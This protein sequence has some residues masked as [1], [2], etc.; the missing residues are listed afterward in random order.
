MSALFTI[1]FRRE[2]YQRE[3]ARVRHR[4][5]MLGVWLIYF[6]V[7]SVILGL[8]GLNCV[9]LARRTHQ[10]ERQTARMRAL[11]NTNREWTVGADEL[12][13]V[14]KLYENPRRLR[15]KLTR[16][17]NL[18]PANATIQ[19]VAVNPD[20]LQGKQDQNQLVITGEL[21]VPAGQDRMRGVVQLVNLL[22]A[23]S[24]FAFGYQNIRLASSRITEG[25]G[26]V[27]AF[28]IEAR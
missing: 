16:L 9:S 13:T 26:A 14:Q 24:T 20:N 28:V 19:S 11:Q 6:G 7:L 3:M 25:S 23:D 1:N 4:V 12:A 27:A 18:M 10:V 2:A 5:V 15:D 17:A 8:Y 21:K 22:R